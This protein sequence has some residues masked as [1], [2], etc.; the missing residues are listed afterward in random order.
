MNVNIVPQKVTSEHLG[1][2]YSRYKR[3]ADPY[4][5]FETFLMA[6]ISI[7]KNKFPELTPIQA[8]KK[9][10]DEYF[11]PAPTDFSIT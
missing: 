4:L 1:I 8:L 11:Q 9:F 2:I 3:K 7:A 10:H 6:V 5:V